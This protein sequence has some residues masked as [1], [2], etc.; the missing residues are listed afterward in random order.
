MTKS[1]FLIKL[2]IFGILLCVFMACANDDYESDDKKNTS[3]ST[4]YNLA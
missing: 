2:S 4:I 3:T 1:S